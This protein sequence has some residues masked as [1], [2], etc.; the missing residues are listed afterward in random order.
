MGMGLEP[1]EEGAGDAA[2]SMAG[3]GCMYEC[4]GQEGGESWQGRALWVGEEG[5]GETGTEKEKN[6]T[7]PQCLCVRRRL[8]VAAAEGRSS[9]CF[10]P[11]DLVLVPP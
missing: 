9:L 5:E 1:C 8:S 7:F 11:L 2:G 3:C 6:K 10:S 4:K